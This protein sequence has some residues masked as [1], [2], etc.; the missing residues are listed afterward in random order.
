MKQSS[1]YLIGLALGLALVG[2]FLFLKY[3]PSLP[4]Q[5]QIAA[6]L[7]AARAAGERRDIGGVMK[8]I[9][10]KYHDS[11][12]PSPIQLRFLL[13]KVAQ[14]DGSVLITQSIPVIALDG[15]KATSTNHL[16]INTS[17][18]GR[19]VYDHDVTMHWQREDGTKLLVVPIKIW[20]V[21][22]ADY[23]GFGFE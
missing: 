7:E 22:S 19:V 15:D 10:E 13:N 5:T 18:D 9:S 1:K 11:N 3:Q 14:G 17:P 16:R 20:R 21:V 23:G 12:V 6:Q 2:I 8:I 4:D